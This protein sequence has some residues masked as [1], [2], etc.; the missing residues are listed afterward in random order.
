M[1]THNKEQT[2][3]ESICGRNESLCQW[4]TCFH[5]ALMAHTELHNPS[6]LKTYNSN[7]GVLSGHLG[8]EKAYHVCWLWGSPGYPGQIWWAVRWRRRNRFGPHRFVRLPTEGSFRSAI[9][10]ATE[11]QTCSW[12]PRSPAWLSR[13]LTYRGEWPSPKLCT[14][15]HTWSTGRI[16]TPASTVPLQE[17]KTGVPRAPRPLGCNGPLNWAWWFGCRLCPCTGE[18]KSADKIHAPGRLFHC[19]LGTELRPAEAT[20]QQPT[21]CKNPSSQV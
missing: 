20:G 10:P 21:S 6:H 2:R 15:A 12:E 8:N 16:L 1:W 3:Q 19:P 9:G 11:S 4:K 7:M 17:G 18:L 13:R 14:Q 5:L